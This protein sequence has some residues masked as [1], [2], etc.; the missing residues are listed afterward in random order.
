MEDCTKTWLMFLCQQA[1]P[2]T[3]VTIAEFIFSRYLTSSQREDIMNRMDMTNAIYPMHTA[4]MYTTICCEDNAT[5]DL[6]LKLIAWGVMVRGGIE[7]MAIVS[8]LFQNNVQS[9]VF[10]AVLLAKMMKFAPLTE[11]LDDE[12]DMLRNEVKYLFEEFKKVPK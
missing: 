7:Y 10:K 2:Q 8:R 4:L 9:P 12:M 3:A 1:H 6:A 11:K 5:A